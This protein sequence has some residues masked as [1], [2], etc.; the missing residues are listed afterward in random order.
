[1]K[2]LLLYTK[3]AECARNEIESLGGQVRQVFTPAVLVA[4]V[5]EDATLSAAT[6]DPPPDL[7]DVSRMMVE[8]WQS[9]A[10]KPRAATEGLPWDTPGFEPPR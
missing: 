3:D 1:M 2:E 9:R 6:I 4:V 7:D 5:P 8:A 10:T